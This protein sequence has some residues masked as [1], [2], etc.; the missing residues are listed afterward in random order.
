MVSEINDVNRSVH[1]VAED[2]ACKPLSS[3]IRNWKNGKS[4]TEEIH[5]G[6]YEYSMVCDVTDEKEEEESLEDVQATEIVECKTLSSF[7]TE[8]RNKNPLPQKSC[9][10]LPLPSNE[11]NLEFVMVTDNE[12]E[13][14]CLVE[15][16]G[17]RGVL[18]TGCSK[19]VA[20]ISWIDQY[21]SIIS[22]DF[23]DSLNIT[24]SKRIYQFG[25]GERRESQGCL[26]L[27]SAIGDKKV[28]ILVEIVDAKIPLLIGS[29]S[30]VVAGAQL[31]FKTNEATFFDEKVPMHCVGSGHFCIELVSEYIETHINDINER[32]GVIENVL[33]TA[34]D[35]DLKGM[36]KLYHRYGQT[37]AEKLLEFLK[38]RRKIR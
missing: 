38:N 23:A 12:Q 17:C 4:S 37:S 21:T 16:A 25:G 18:D 2:I 27:P 13:L 3:L 15:E 35:I 36:K 26:D 24:P 9:L 31:D 8:W 6:Q 11:D 33:M 29:N 14:C 10:V 1:S 30:M 5:P 20:G 32:Y 22:P 34:D 28:A 19:S 7:L